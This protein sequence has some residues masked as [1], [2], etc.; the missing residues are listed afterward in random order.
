MLAL[1]LKV[2]PQFLLRAVCQV[3]ERVLLDGGP[4]R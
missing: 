4:C 1:Q 3:L 2:F